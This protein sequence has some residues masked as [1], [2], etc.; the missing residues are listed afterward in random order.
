MG[1]LIRCP[2]LNPYYHWVILG[3]LLLCVLMMHNR[4]NFLELGADQALHQIKK[5]VLLAESEERIQ[6]TRQSQSQKESLVEKE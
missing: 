6:Y 3:K 2:R 4:A 5:R 1:S